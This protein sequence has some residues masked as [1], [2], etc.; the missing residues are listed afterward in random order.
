MAEPNPLTN[1]GDATPEII[2]NVGGGSVATIIGLFIQVVLGFL[3]VI[4]LILIIYSGFIWMT[5]SG[6]ATKV[7]KARSVIINSIIGLV[8]VL[9]AYAITT[10]ILTALGV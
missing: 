5:A 9:A 3:G 6:D 1:L 8:I 7:A 2:K 10:L 4:F